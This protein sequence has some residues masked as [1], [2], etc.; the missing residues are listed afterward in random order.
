M[1]DDNSANGLARKKCFVVT[2]IGTPESPIRRSTEGLIDAALRP[3]LDKLK[4]D[5]FVAHEISTPGSITR[6]VLEHLLKDDLVIANLSGLNPNVMYELGVRHSAR[7]PVVVLAESGTVLPFD[8]ATERTIFFTNDMKGVEELKPHL[9]RAVSDAVGENEPDNPV[10]RAVESNVMRQVKPN[11]DLNQYV[12]DRLDRIEASI[13]GIRTSR[14]PSSG[15]HTE[16]PSKV[17]VSFT[18][19]RGEDPREAFYRVKQMFPAV[20]GGW[21]SSS[22]TV[23]IRT[24]SMSDAQA[25][26]E[27]V[28]R[29]G[30]ADTSSILIDEFP[31][32]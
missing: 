18:V 3:I 8:L 20:R 11:G 15:A 10:Y 31:L 21:S 6:Q 29:S 25:I 4:F 24:A 2:P 16:K 17:S 14:A 9:E 1:A 7:L 13:D 12:L 22:R 26:R 30:A 28:S 27:A 19:K 32:D 23:F 5:V